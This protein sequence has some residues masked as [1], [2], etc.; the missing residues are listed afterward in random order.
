MEVETLELIWGDWYASA[1]T[2]RTFQEFPLPKAG[3]PR[4][5]PI[6]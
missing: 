5:H 1:N 6:S 4:H 3:S 2:L